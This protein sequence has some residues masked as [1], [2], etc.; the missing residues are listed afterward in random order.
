MCERANVASQRASKQHDT[1]WRSRKLTQILR[2]PEI[3]NNHFEKQHDPR[4]A[5]PA[6]LTRQR[7]CCERY[8]ES[9]QYVGLG[10][11]TPSPSRLWTKAGSHTVCMSIV[12]EYPREHNGDGSTVQRSVGTL[13][14][15]GT[16]EK[17][18]CVSELLRGPFTRLKTP[19]GT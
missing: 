10:V 8:I 7:K 18:E 13:S 12:I 5:P 4:T 6:L 14:I 16:W 9:L 11:P 17:S 1:R 2:H 19:H 3:K 15:A